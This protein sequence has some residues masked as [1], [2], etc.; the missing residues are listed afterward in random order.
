MQN[1]RNFLHICIVFTQVLSGFSKAAFDADVALYT[2]TLSEAIAAS[3]AGVAP[4]DVSDIVVTAGAANGARVVHL[5]T[6]PFISELEGLR[7]HR[8]LQEMPPAVTVTYKVTTTTAYTSKQL[9]AQ[10]EESLNSGAFVETL[11]EKAAE[12]GAMSLISAVQV[13]LTP[14]AEPTAAVSAFPSAS[15]TALAKFK[16]K[17]VIFEFFFRAYFFVHEI[18]S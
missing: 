16:I 8:A 6:L 1:Q 15:T 4:S 12:A 3:M 9:K 18:V 13:A 10:M 2:A 5:H 17:Q 14:T 11:H 7:V